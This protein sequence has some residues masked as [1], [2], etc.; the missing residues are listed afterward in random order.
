MV[1]K[2]FLDANVLLDFLLKRANY[3]NAKEVLKPYN[4]WQGKSFYHSCHSSYC[5]LLAY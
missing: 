4:Q 3:Q 5:G 1:F 2:V